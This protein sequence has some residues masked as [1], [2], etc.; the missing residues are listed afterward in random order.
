MCGRRVP[1]A[2]GARA[3]RI[4][5]ARWRSRAP[6]VTPDAKVR[7][8]SRGT[9]RGA[10]GER[11]ADRVARGLHSVA[12]GSSASDVRR[13]IGRCV[14]MTVWLPA[15]PPG[16][17]ATRPPAARTAWGVMVQ[18]ALAYASPRN[19]ARVHRLGMPAFM[20]IV[21]AMVAPRC[22]QRVPRTVRWLRGRRQP[23][24][25]GHGRGRGRSGTQLASLA[26]SALLL[27]TALFLALVPGSAAG[28]PGC[29]RRRVGA[30]LRLPSARRP[31]QI[32]IDGGAGVPSP[33]SRAS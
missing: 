8:V 32:A 11:D 29:H 14:P 15:Y 24:P 17:A 16:L 1:G 12:R 21:T 30:R 6:R 18:V 28:C 13:L 2:T 5:P 25:V 9:P 31:R 10:R 19:D 22:R 27:A 23:V 33:G 4:V 3:I 7:R 20:G 26:T